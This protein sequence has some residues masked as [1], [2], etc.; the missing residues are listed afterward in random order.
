MQDS[1]S[2]AALKGHREPP[3]VTRPPCSPTSS[4]LG[5]PLPTPGPSG[6]GAVPALVSPGPA[7]SLSG[8]HLLGASPHP[9]PTSREQELAPGARLL[10]TR[11]CRRRVW[12][13]GP[14]AQ[15]EGA[16]CPG[17]NRLALGAG[18]DR[19][20]AGGAGKVAT[21]LG[22]FAGHPG[23]RAGTVLPP[24]LP[25]ASERC[26]RAPGAGLAPEVLP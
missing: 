18:A 5:F 2:L 17:G 7:R 6:A 4:G 20:R 22:N 21:Q 25:R 13:K 11:P 10:W 19:L 12:R 24:R 16:R 14:R 9:T 15:R 26:E 1:A 23:D 3:Q 8:P